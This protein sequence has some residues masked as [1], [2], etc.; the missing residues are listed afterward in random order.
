MSRRRNKAESSL[1]GALLLLLLFFICAQST[2][3]DPLCSRFLVAV[4]LR[5][6]HQHEK[7]LQAATRHKT[8][9]SWHKRSSSTEE[10]LAGA[11]ES[12][13]SCAICLSDMIIGDE[14]IDT[15]CGHSFHIDCL[16][17]WVRQRGDF[18][19]P[20]GVTSVFWTCPVCRTLY[21]SWSPVPGTEPSGNGPLLRWRIESSARQVLTP[22]ACEASIRDLEGEMTRREAREVAS[23]SISDVIDVSHANALAGI[24]PVLASPTRPFPMLLLR[25]SCRCQNNH[26]NLLARDVHCRCAHISILRCLVTARVANQQHTQVC[27]SICPSCSPRSL[28]QPSFCYSASWRCTTRRPPPGEKASAGELLFCARRGHCA[29]TAC[30]HRVFFRGTRSPQSRTTIYK[31]PTISS[32][33]RWASSMIML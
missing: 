11:L 26:H 21:K 22:E 24:V 16:R 30:A 1:L 32:I 14:V 2:H 28:G 8:M 20:T 5:S 23:R 4:R 27:D 29:P 15:S 19:P 13:S 12:S 25:R 6:I 31:Q 9:P 17:M 18:Q 10:E 7:R 3:S 33:Q